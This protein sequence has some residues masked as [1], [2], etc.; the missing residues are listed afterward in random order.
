MRVGD[1]IRVRYRG[2]DP[3]YHGVAYKKPITLDEHHVW[4]MW[5]FERRMEHVLVPEIDQIEVVSEK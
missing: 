2:I 3:W 1:L 4:R 5:C